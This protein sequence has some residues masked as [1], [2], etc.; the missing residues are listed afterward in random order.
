MQQPYDTAPVSSTGQPRHTFRNPILLQR[1]DPWVYKHTDGY[2]YFTA[3]V[4]E[5][6]RIEIRRAATIQGLGTA[7]PVTVWHKHN[8]GPMSANIWAPEIHHMD[9]SWYIYFAAGHSEEHFRIRSY[10][11]ENSSPNPLE[12]E[13]VERELQVHW[14]SFTLD[15]TTFEHHGTRY[16]VWAQGHPDIPGNSNLYIAPLTNPWTI[17][18][19]PVLLT[20]PELPW[21]IKGYLVN[22]GPAV[23]KR[24]GRI[25]ISYSASATNHHYCMGLLTA[26]E[27]S[28]LL[29]PASWTKSPAPVFQSCDTAGQYGPG[30]NS[31]TVSEDGTED[32]FVYHARNYKDIEGEPL[33]DPNR[34]TRAQVLRWN[35]DGTPNFGTPEAD[36]LE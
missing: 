21:E 27:N 11:L 34:H 1:A 31:F 30:H 7:D 13:W 14:D 2:Y 23:L 12:G 18:S 5:F 26:S 24:N 9:G 10:V 16:L 3:S 22:E 19:A 33:F 4:P 8:E 17:A 35:D 15:V 32:I 28:D 29:N 20:K 6:D 25:F 36:W